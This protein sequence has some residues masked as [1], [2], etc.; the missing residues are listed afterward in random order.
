MT[1][2][3][4]AVPC[5][6]AAG[7]GFTW[8]ESAAGPILAC[9]P[10]QAIAAHGWTT[11]QLQLQG[12]EQACGREWERLAA[13]AVMP[14]RA[15][16][17]M[18]QVHGNTITA[19]RREAPEAP[20]AD[21]LTSDD[22]SLLLAVRVADCV[23]LL[24]ADRRS[25]AVAAVHAG[26]RG[27]AAGIAREA[28][29]GMWELYGSPAD[30]VV[31]ALGPSIGTC[32]Y[33]VGPDVEAAFRDAGW[34]ERMLDRWFTRDHGALR[35]DVAAAVADQLRGAGVTRESVHVSGLCTACHPESFYS[36]RR[37]GAGTGRL[38]GFIRAQPAEG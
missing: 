5:H 19:A 35:L 25:G 36:Y 8:R 28:I 13:A 3:L 22:G 32:H 30:A 1:D 20:R 37:D 21:A 16:R 4:R 11:R 24:V 6:P 9:G 18:H 38:V 14:V 31:A 17:R 23:P 10:L 12:P 26:W 2:T 33:E 29:R 34:P 7:A 27:A 15:I